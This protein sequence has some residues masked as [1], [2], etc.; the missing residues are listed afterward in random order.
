M[1][2]EHDPRATM[3][4]ARA[5]YDNLG[6]PKWFVEFPGAGHE[7]LLGVDAELWKEQVQHFLFEGTR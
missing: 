6:G 3:A 1:H 2:G 7:A 4:E 5:V